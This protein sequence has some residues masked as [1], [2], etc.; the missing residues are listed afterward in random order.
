MVNAIEDKLASSKL[1]Q[2]VVIIISMILSVSVASISVGK[3]LTRLDGKI[4]LN[5]ERI[6]AINMINARLD[7]IELWQE[8]APPDAFE[9]L[10]EEFRQDMKDALKELRTDI[11]CLRDEI[12]YSRKEQ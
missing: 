4:N 1:L 6:N 2:T 8:N 10:M 3:E 11:S 9:K 7:K 5:T 12:N